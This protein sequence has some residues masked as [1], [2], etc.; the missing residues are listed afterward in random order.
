MQSPPGY[1][2]PEAATRALPSRA[3]GGEL[4]E[5][6]HEPERQLHRR[7]QSLDSRLELERQEQPIIQEAHE[8][9]EVNQQR[10]EP[11][12]EAWVHIDEAVRSIIDQAASGTESDGKTSESE[13]EEEAQQLLTEGAEEWYIWTM[14]ESNG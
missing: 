6:D 3:A 8:Q 12:V 9:Q 4:A 5:L 14:D 11:I 10:P 2:T 7:R 1:T 13:S